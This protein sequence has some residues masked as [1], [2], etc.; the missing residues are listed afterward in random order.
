MKRIISV[1]I[2]FSVVISC[3]GLGAHAENNKKS[4]PIILISGFLCS[5]L[6]MN[7]AA[8]D[9][10]KVW[11]F[12]A[13]TIIDRI[14]DD[15]SA[16][17]KGFAGLALGK[18]EKLGVTL[19][20]AAGAILEDLRCNPDGSS[21]YPVSHYPNNPAYSNIKYMLENG[22]EENM[23]EKKF[24]KYLASIADASEIFC[25]QYDSRFDAVTIAGQLNDFVEQ[26]KDY[27]NSDKVR[28]FALSFGGLISVSYLY[29]YG[30]SS[31]S[32]LIM[33][34]PALGGTNI[35]ERLF[36]GKID[37]SIEET[38]K[39]F[40]TILGS[41][42]NI[43]R[44]FEYDSVDRL[45]EI[46]SIASD[47]MRSALKYWGSIW[48][49]CSVDSY[50]ELKAEFLDP[51]EN[52]ALIEKTDKIHYEIMPAV[53]EILKNAQKNGTDVAVLCGTGSPLV[54]GGELNGDYILPASSVSG[55]LCA[56][57]GKR[58]ADGYTGIKTACNNPAHNHISPSMQIDASSAYLPEN[59][60]FI[61]GQYHGQY[62]YEEYTRSLVTKLLLTDEIKDVY[63]SPEYPQFEY[64]NNAYRNIHVRFN[65]SPSGYLNSEDTALF[66]ENTSK[67]N[68]IKILAV[69]ANG[70]DLSFDVSDA[71]MLAPSETVA[72]PFRGAVG[73]KGSTAAQITVSYIEVGSIN[74]FCVSEFSVMID[75]GEGEGDGGFVPLSFKSKFETSIPDWLCNFLERASLRQ[76]VECIYNAILSVIRK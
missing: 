6:Y 60:W 36:R 47:G 19:G 21:K 45:N 69:T 49:L 41:E 26:V 20:N 54:I 66:V 43:A 62:Y 27:T 31:V 40:E 35:P 1:L 14:G 74:P 61:E 5:Q 22:K 46:I 39:F 50:D 76:G 17:A 28:I 11:F 57:E 53:S 65:S 70:A 68:R 3:F 23:Y 29:L 2:C 71:E 52:A 75:N 72:I 4:D 33:S 32:K 34:V 59:T 12:E 25:F 10:K 64:S 51:V 24:C 37:L 38:V 8:D 16:F 58:F 44:I 56:P 48:S 42:S 63:S 55:A 7:Y 30:D 73:D 18:T 9:E 15:F 67:D 13:D